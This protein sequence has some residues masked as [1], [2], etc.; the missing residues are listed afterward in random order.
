M[1]RS[2]PVFDEDF[3]SQGN[4]RLLFGAHFAGT[5]D[6]DTKG[7]PFGVVRLKFGSSL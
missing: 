7:D 6:R 4:V 1:G 3:G 2:L 5:R